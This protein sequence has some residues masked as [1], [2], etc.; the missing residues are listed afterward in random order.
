MKGAKPA[1][2][3]VWQTSKFDLVINLKTARAM[4]LDIP[5]RLMALADDV[6]D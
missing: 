2:L 6:I 3:P 1:E 4:G 5:D